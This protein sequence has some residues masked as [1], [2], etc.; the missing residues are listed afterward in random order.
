MY[1][2]KI[3]AQ[4]SSAQYPPVS[5]LP[6]CGEK[7]PTQCNGGSHTG[8]EKG[9]RQATGCLVSG[10]LP[11]KPETLRSREIDHALL[12]RLNGNQPGDDTIRASVCYSGE[13]HAILSASRLN[14]LGSDLKGFTGQALDV[15]IGNEI[16]L[17][18]AELRR[19]IDEDLAAAL[20]ALQEALQCH[21]QAGLRRQ[22]FSQD[23]RIL[24]THSGGDNVWPPG[25]SGG[26]NHG[27]HSRRR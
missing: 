12:L 22:F 20:R 9:R 26:G 6:G 17:P 11:L 19:D 3:N 7:C 10:P 18:L 8:R 16:P 15:S 2:C 21:G 14:R 5:S 13:F 27:E 25:A 23:N 4:F 1:A 24:N